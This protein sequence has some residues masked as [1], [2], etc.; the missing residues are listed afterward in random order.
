V[1]RVQ[2]RILEV[3]ER[4]V[5][6]SEQINNRLNNFDLLMNQTVQGQTQRITRIEETLG[7][8]AE[9]MRNM[10]ITLGRINEEV[11]DGFQ[12]QTTRMQEVRLRT[13]ETFDLLKQIG[14][15]AQAESE[16]QREE[17]RR[18]SLDAPQ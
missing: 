8:M 14:A 10:T 13:R 12:D 15:D 4:S 11:T 7:R 6:N 1:D 3:F 16:H 5:E 17:S 9:G 2:Q 18:T